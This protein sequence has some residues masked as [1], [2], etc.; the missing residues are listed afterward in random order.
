[1]LGAMA[2][3]LPPSFALRVRWFKTWLDPSRAGHPPRCGRQCCDQG[4]VRVHTARFAYSGQMAQEIV[5]SATEQSPAAPS[6]DATR[7]RGAIARLARR[8]RPP[9]PAA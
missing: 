5:V 8:L 9:P 7:L 4:Y 1:M 3:M 2:T 6:I